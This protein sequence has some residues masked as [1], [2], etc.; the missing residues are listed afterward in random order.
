MEVPPIGTDSHVETTVDIHHPGGIGDIMQV[1][2]GGSWLRGVIQ[3]AVEDNSEV[4]YVAV[5]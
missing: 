3:D 2:D 4:Q 5:G 1:A